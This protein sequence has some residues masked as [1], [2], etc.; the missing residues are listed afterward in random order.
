M[1]HTRKVVEAMSPSEL[2][3][4]TMNLVRNCAGLEAEL[5]IHLGQIDHQKLYLDCACPS[6]FVF[7]VQS[8]G[9]SED[10]ACTR[11]AVARAA[12]NIPAILDSVRSGAIHLTGLRLL[13]PHLTAENH[14]GVL[15]RAAGKTKR[16]IEELIA[17]LCPRAPV[18]TMVRK[19]PERVAPSPDANT[20]PVASR[21]NPP[22]WTVDSSVA[23][24][25]PG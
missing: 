4:A 18:P 25:R 20:S 23:T 1:I 2:L 13:L 19:L 10:V 21:A 7:C 5:L 8:Y 6:M 15:S 9:F 16:E 14:D 22:P 3:V 12:R 24:S 11:I 17:S